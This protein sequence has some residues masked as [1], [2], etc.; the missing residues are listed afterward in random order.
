[1]LNV[2]SALPIKALYC[3]SGPSV[4]TTLILGIKGMINRPLFFLLSRRHFTLMGLDRHEE[5]QL[6]PD[7]TIS[8]SFSHSHVAIQGPGSLYS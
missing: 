7:R 3:K 4:A 8:A 5:F 6:F 1:M 2:C